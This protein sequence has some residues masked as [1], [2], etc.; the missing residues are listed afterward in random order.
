MKAREI[1]FLKYVY[2]E[3]EKL[4]INEL[5]LEKAI[6]GAEKEHWEQAVK[7]ELQ[8]FEENNAWE[9]VD[10]PNSGTLVKCK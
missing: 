6:Q 9:L 7:E 2:T 10:A 5:T 4:D 1:W 8:C 3:I